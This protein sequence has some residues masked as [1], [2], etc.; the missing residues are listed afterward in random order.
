M[1]MSKWVLL[2][3]IALIVIAALGW[4]VFNTNSN[5]D[6]TPEFGVGG[7]PGNTS[8][9]TTNQT[10]IDDGFNLNALF[11]EHAISATL[12]LQNL[13]DNKDTTESEKN[14][15][16][17]SVK[18]AEFFDKHIEGDI[19]G[20]FLNM[21]DGHNKEYENYTRALK[22]GDRNGT[23]QARGNLARQA[24]EMGTMVNQ[25]IPALPADRFTQLMNE[26]VD[27]TLSIIEAHA[28]GDNAAKATQ[29]AKASTQAVGF[30]NTITDALD[31][32]R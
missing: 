13:Y 10:N 12:H 18:V 21:W 14:V 25:W 17:N 11:Q 9:Q 32:P 8:N 26:H 1:P 5:R 23:A 27:L 31:E 28:S 7:G 6:N 15:E 2:P 16:E 30:A 24:T 20:E 4:G 29:T 19:K 22:A 3:I